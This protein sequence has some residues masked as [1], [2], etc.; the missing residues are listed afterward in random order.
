MEE[1]AEQVPD[2]P[3]LFLLKDSMS[4]GFIQ[5]SVPDPKELPKGLALSP[6]K[7]YLLKFIRENMVPINSVLSAGGSDPSPASFQTARALDFD[8]HGGVGI[9]GQDYTNSAATTIGAYPHPK[10]SQKYR[11]RSV[12]CPNPIKRVLDLVLKAR[13]IGPITETRA[14]LF[15]SRVEKSRKSPSKKRN[16]RLQR[17]LR[18][19]NPFLNYQGGCCRR[20]KCFKSLDPSHLFNGFKK[21]SEL[22]SVQTKWYLIS[23]FSSGGRM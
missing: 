3:L 2:G 16:A 5:Y 10:G 4:K 20:F 18:S 6:S 14:Y 15:H 19:R 23:L 12:L 7:K 8:C 9:A 13:W 1:R 22:N 21:V 17:D 11:A